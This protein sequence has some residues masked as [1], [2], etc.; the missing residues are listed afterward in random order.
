MSLSIQNAPAFN[1]VYYTDNAYLKSGEHLY[2]N[3]DSV[4]C[5]KCNK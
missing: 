2:D 5:D 1:C 4:Y 3:I